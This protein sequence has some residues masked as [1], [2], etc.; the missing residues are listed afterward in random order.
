MLPL[1]NT[2]W[3]IQAQTEGLNNPSLNFGWV[4]VRANAVTIK[5]WREMKEWWLRTK[6]GDPDHWDQVRPGGWLG[7]HAVGGLAPAAATTSPP[8]P[9]AVRRSG[10]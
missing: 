3:D 4:W 6:Q 8:A 1:S 5:L 7:A 10:S 2:T 9:A